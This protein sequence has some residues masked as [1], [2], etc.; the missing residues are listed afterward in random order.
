MQEPVSATAIL[1]VEDS[2]PLATLYRQYL[3][4]QG[5]QVVHAES[6]SEAVQ[7]L[8][9]HEFQLV[10]LD[11]TLPDMHGFDVLRFINDNTIDVPTVVVTANDSATVAMDAVHLGAVDFLTKPI[12]ASRLMLTV[13][14]VLKQHRLEDMVD[15]YQQRYE[16]DQFE[17]LVGASPMMQGV[18]RIIESAASSRA[19]IFIT[20][21]SGT[22]KELCAEAIHRRSDRSDKPLI[23]I[24]CAAIPRELMESEIFGHMKG[25]FTGAHAERDGAATL[26]NGGTLFLDE[27]CEMD[28]DLQSKLL[29]F[30]QLGTFQKVGSS[31]SQQVDIRFVCATNRDPL[32]EVR[33][34]RF[35]E[36]LYYRLHVIP[37]RVPPLRERGSDCM[38]IANK[39]LGSI[40]ARENK[41]FQSF[42]SEVQSIMQ[43]YPWPG[44]VRELENVIMNMVVLGEGREI[45]CDMLPDSLGSAL[46]RGA[47]EVRVQRS[48]A[49]APLA[50]ESEP[51]RSDG[52]ISPLWLEEKRIIERAI[53]ICGGNLPKAAALL[54]VSAS[55]L[56]RKRQV[57]EK[58]S[59]QSELG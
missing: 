40:N 47:A 4:T 30:I 23:T 28:L 37:L 3:E 14:N 33:A 9:Q 18:Y 20:G 8:T 45:T 21:E 38:L 25:A 51:R 46:E 29:R 52:E 7:A 34:G 27:L 59:A 58:D 13:N 57:W 35:R 48:S 15:S 41:S 26:A 55:T 44:N 16:R 50:A 5:H 2:L 19:S 36:D 10:L 24:N 32:E 49:I 42:S 1:L 39:L 31:V 6:G 56:Y 54:E 17:S 22:G 43:A 11:L 53:A 12:D